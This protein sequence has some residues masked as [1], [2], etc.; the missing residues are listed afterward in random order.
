MLKNPITART[1]QYILPV[2]CLENAVF[3]CY[4]VF[5]QIKLFLLHFKYFLLYAVFCDCLVNKNLLFLVYP[6]RPVNRLHLSS[7]VPPRVNNKHIIRSCKV[8]PK[9]ACFQ[10]YK[11]TF[12]EL[13]FWKVSTTFFLFAVEPSR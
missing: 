4:Y 7:R 8:Q 5:H 11:N 6:V 1:M 3:N 9:P 13:S 2:Q 12:I 10:A